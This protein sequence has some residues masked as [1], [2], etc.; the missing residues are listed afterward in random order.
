MPRVGALR[1]PD[2]LQAN[3]PAM[4]GSGI[5]KGRMRPWPEN[6]SLS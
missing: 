1:F 2:S 4:I 3:G 6:T 5:G